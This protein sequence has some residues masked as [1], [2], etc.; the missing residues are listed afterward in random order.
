MKE[1]TV[2]LLKECSSGCKMAVNSI[3]QV[4]AYVEDE[5]LQEILDCY[6]L[7]HEK[8]MEKTGRLL[9]EAGE[10]PEKPGMMA[11]AFS[12]LSTEI[13]MLVKGSTSKV[14]K[15]MMDGCNM[16]IQSIAKYKNQYKEADKEAVKT[17]QDLIDM[18]EEFSKKMERFICR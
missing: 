5:N 6:K 8:I 1:D 14:A 12:W 9:S 2:K 3:D 11:S 15:I 18:E 10:G 16:G 13:K 17:A 4:Q 7:K